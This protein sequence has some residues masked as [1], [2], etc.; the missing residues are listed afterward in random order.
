MELGG[1]RVTVAMDLEG[2]LCGL[3][4]YGKAGLGDDI[5]RRC[6]ARTRERM[7]Q[8]RPQLTPLPLDR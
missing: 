4:S 6:V 3:T 2:R 7:E 1:A 5:L 8:L